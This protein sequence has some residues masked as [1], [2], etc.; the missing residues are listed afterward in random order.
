MDLETP[1]F[2]QEPVDLFLFPHGEGGQDEYDSGEAA[3]T[4]S[5]EKKSLHPAIL[6]VCKSFLNGIPT[7]KPR[8]KMENE[9]LSGFQSKV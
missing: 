2:F 3:F 7:M 6:A 8:E 9:I 1:A 4:N 5:H